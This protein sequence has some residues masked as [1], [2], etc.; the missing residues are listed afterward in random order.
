LQCLDEFT[1]ATGLTAWG[2]LFVIAHNQNS[3]VGKI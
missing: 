2:Q 3:L 1:I